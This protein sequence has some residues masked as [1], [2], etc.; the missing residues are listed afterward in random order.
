MRS[1]CIRTYI[2]NWIRFC[3]SSLNFVY[4]SLTLQITNSGVRV[5][6]ANRPWSTGNVTTRRFDYRKSGNPT[7]MTKGRKAAIQT[8]C[9]C[10]FI[11]FQGRRLRPSTSKDTTELRRRINT[12]IGNITQDMLQRIWRE[13]E[14]GLDISCTRGA[15]I[16]C[17]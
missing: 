4:V 3:Y 12:A 13:W 17:I 2:M 15:Y 9:V 11:V 7:A 16:E 5:I 8:E 1:I 6:R 14:Y 10:I